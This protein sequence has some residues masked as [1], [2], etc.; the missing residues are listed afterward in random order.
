MNR[1]SVLV[2]ALIATGPFLVRVAQGQGSVKLRPLNCNAAPA[3]SDCGS[4]QPKP[5][6]LYML[7]SKA[8]LSDGRDLCIDVD[9]GTGRYQQLDCRKSVPSRQFYFSTGKRPDHCY[10]IEQERLGGRETATNMVGIGFNQV[11]STCRAAVL[12]VQWQLVAAPGGFFQIKN[13]QEGLCITAGSDGL[14]PTDPITTRPCPANAHPAN[15]Q[16][17]MLF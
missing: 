16:L 9:P 14:S 1:R 13:E 8:K 4:P 5:D 2:I 6:G 3:I 7:K 12:E 11:D 15:N 17:W 10:R